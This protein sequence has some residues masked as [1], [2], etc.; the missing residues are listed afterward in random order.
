MKNI[1]VNEI[2]DYIIKNNGP[3]PDGRGHPFINRLS[4]KD[5][6]DALAIAYEKKCC[7]NIKPYHFR[8]ITGIYNNEWIINELIEKKIDQLLKMKYRGDLVNLI[9]E[10]SSKDILSPFREDKDGK[11]IRIDLVKIVEKIANNT[12]RPYAI[13]S[14]YI[15]IKGLEKRYKGL[16]PYHFTIT[17]GGTYDDPDIVDEL[18]V[19]KIDQLLEEK[20]KKDI[21]LLIQNTNLN[22]LLT[23]FVDHLDGKSINVNM[24]TVAKKVNGKKQS[25]FSMI[26]HYIKLKG[27]ADKFK[28]LKPYHFNRTSWKTYN[29][30][31]VLSNLLVMKID[32]L[33]QDKYNGDLVSLI[34]RTTME[35]L[36][37]PFVDRLD[38]K[39]INVSMIVVRKK[40]LKNN[41]ERGFSIISNYIKL[42]GLEKKYKGFKPY[43]LKVSPAGIYND[44]KISNEVFKKKIDQLLSER[45]GNKLKRMLKEVTL[46]EMLGPYIDYIDGKP[47]P[48]SMAMVK[49]KIGKG[50]IYKGKNIKKNMLKYYLKLIGKENRLD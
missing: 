6:T 17:S 9:T 7:N 42:K 23:P 33:L 21:I 25:P 31:K 30:Q 10:A 44:P 29:N 48:V 27:L 49:L 36:F 12:S 50:K 32:Q 13:I 28:E 40:M 47:I 18:L 37:S 20:Y 19:K 34:K 15:E 8:Y 35:E 45:Y 26:S 1:T 3:D 43:H 39:P 14:R 5:L 16:K 2:V 41:K 24:L 38:G 4:Y 46:T 11:K 22:E